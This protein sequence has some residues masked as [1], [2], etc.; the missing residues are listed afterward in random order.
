MQRLTA[1]LSGMCLLFVGLTMG[2]AQ[3]MSDSTTPPPKVLVIFR[4]AG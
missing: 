2:M 3:E 1:L 4:E